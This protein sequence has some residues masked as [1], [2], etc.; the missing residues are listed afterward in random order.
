MSQTPKNI[1]RIIFKI[2]NEQQEIT[3]FFHKKK[4]LK[5]FFNNKY[6]TPKQTLA[7][8]YPTVIIITV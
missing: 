8:I 5:A 3:I 2:V 1:F 6:F 4:K 7:L